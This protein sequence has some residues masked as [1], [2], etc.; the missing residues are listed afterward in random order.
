[1]VSVLTPSS[2][3]TWRKICQSH[4]NS[5]VRVLW[6]QHSRVFNN[7]CYV[8]VSKKYKFGLR[9]SFFK[10]KIRK[11]SMHETVWW[12]KQANL[13]MNLT[14]TIASKTCHW[15]TL[16]HFLLLFNE[17]NLLLQIIVKH[18]TTAI[19]NLMYQ[20]ALKMTCISNHF[21]RF[22]IKFCEKWQQKIIFW[23]YVIMLIK[24]SFSVTVL[25]FYTTDEQTYF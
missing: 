25:H 14:F 2:F 1:M 18:S 19:Q 21:L 9:V 24:K 5:T 23:I 4:F 15:I 20:C 10:A 22:N 16:Q 17:F 13:R 7:D 12:A 8:Y 3:S 6:A 11:Q